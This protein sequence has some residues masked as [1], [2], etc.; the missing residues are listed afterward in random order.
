MD[1]V[2]HMP[3]CAKN[4]HWPGVEPEDDSKPCDPVAAGIAYHHGI[5]IWYVIIFQKAC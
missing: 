5:E 4:E 2:P 1:I 3:P